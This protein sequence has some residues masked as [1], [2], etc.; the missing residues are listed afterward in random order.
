MLRIDLEAS[1][2][3]VKV[4]RMVKIEMRHSGQ[5]HG[6]MALDSLWMGILVSFRNFSESRRGPISGQAE[7]RYLE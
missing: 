3:D 1:H 7:R 6:T 4:N 2:N 5:G